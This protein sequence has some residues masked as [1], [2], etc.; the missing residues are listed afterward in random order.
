M[1]TVNIS[2]FGM[3]GLSARQHYC[4]RDDNRKYA[5]DDPQKENPI[6]MLQRNGYLDVSMRSS[7]NIVANLSEL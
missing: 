2:G 1:A 5:R 6:T 4:Q 7:G 3:H